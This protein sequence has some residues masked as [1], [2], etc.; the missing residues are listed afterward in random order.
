MTCNTLTISQ[1]GRSRRCVNI[2]FGDNKFL[3]KDAAASSC[4]V[5]LRHRLREDLLPCILMTVLLRSVIRR[6]R[7]RHTG[8]ST[9]SL[10]PPS[11]SSP[12]RQILSRIPCRAV[13]SKKRFCSS[14]HRTRIR[15]DYVDL[16]WN[17]W[18]TD[19]CCLQISD[20]DLYD[21][22]RLCGDA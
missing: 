16:S 8:F 4:T 6:M 15:N 11:L 3:S 7:Y 2:P 5:R 19:E 9:R 14:I 22:A 17:L 1:D 21:D 13:I 10:P 18:Q 20:I 12:S